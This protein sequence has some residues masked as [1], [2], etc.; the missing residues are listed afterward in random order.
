MSNAAPLITKPKVLLQY[1]NKE[2]VY[3]PPLPH[4]T[5]PILDKDFTSAAL[6]CEV[7]GPIAVAPFC[8][9]LC[10]P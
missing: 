1:K 3:I 4:S 10:V 9:A 5:D 6:A 2:L 7:R 8:P